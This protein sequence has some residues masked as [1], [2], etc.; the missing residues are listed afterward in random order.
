MEVLEAGVVRAVC[1]GGQ[2]VSPEEGHRGRHLLAL[3]SQRAEHTR[4]LG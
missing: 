2:G 4:R 1:V 3:G